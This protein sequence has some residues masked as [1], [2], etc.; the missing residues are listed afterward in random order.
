MRSTDAARIQTIVAHVWPQ[1]G[2]R[3][4]ALAWAAICPP[5]LA[6]LTVTITNFCLEN[7]SR[8]RSNATATNLLFPLM[9]GGMA[10]L[11][12]AIYFNCRTAET[13]A[14]T[15]SRIQALI[16]I[17]S[18]ITLTV[19]AVA[20]TGQAERRQVSQASELVIFLCLPVLLVCAGLLWHATSIIRSPFRRALMLTG[21]LA[22]TALVELWGDNQTQRNAEERLFMLNSMLVALAFAI[23]LVVW[24]AKE[25]GRR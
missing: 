24:S 3:M 12:A 5:S 1:T 2:R 16:G 9:V 20:V 22:A 6:I 25:F 17:S 23:Q 19:L 21:F 10:I 8:E 18:A 7:T 4:F 14:A 15:N 11:L 13:P